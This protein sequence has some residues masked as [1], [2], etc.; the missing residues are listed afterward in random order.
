MILASV[1]IPTHNR[2]LLLERLLRS[3]EAQT[4]PADSFEV[5]IVHNHTPDGTEEMAREWCAR[6]TFKA[7]YFQKNYKGPTRS[8][9][10][11]ARTAEGR[12][13]VFIDDDC[14]ATPRWLEEG[15]A[16]FDAKGKDH[17][18]G[19]VQGMTTPMPG[20]PQRFPFKTINIVEPTVFFETCNIFYLKDAFEAVGGF[21]EDFLD[22]F[23]GEDTDLGWKVTQQGF[24]A[25]F[26]PGALAHHEVFQVSL[27]QWLAE[28]LHFKNLPYLVKKYPAL[29]ERMFARYF[30]TRDT[31]FFN[32]LWLA[33][34]LSPL[35]AWAG[36]LALPYF[37]ERLRGGSHVGGW[38]LRILRVIAGLPRNLFMWWAL[39]RGSVRARTVLL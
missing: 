15:L 34:L 1:V 14:I 27:R 12:H 2:R 18:I 5:L 22:R 17:P 24:A 10:F 9:E 11:G 7:R 3:L 20:Q 23:Y 13:V 37:I 38:K 32:F 36:L 28:P 33:L 35:S 16:A 30:L 26:A 31:C 21:S 25:G 39:A 6:Q 4:L 8:R 19:L 29:R